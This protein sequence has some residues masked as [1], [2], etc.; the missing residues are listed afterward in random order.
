MHFGRIKAAVSAECSKGQKS[1]ACLASQQCWRTIEKN[2]VLFTLF[3]L[4]SLHC[5]KPCAAVAVFECACDVQQC[6]VRAV[7]WMV[8]MEQPE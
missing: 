6:K 1:S 7:N 2:C 3:E 5:L 8:N 4:I